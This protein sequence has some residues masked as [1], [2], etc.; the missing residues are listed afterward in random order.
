MLNTSTQFDNNHIK[1]SDSIESSHSDMSL[2]E[3]LTNQKDL[4]A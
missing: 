2:L 3:I 4:S 1:A